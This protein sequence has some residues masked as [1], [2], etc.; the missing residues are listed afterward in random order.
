[1]LSL[2]TIYFLLIKAG[3]SAAFECEIE[4]KYVTWL[5][6]NKPISDRLADRMTQMSCGNL[7]RLEILNVTES[8]AGVYT[9]HAKTSD[10]VVSTCTA[11]LVVYKRK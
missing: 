7:H 11:N 2:L 10:G 1:M 6:D 5:K 4:A 8:D 9:A 3:G